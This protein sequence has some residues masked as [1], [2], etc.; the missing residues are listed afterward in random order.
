MEY[1][2]HGTPF[3]L[4]CKRG[5]VKQCFLHNPKQ[6]VNATN[7]ISLYLDHTI[8]DDDLELLKFIWKAEFSVQEQI[9]R[10][11]LAHDIQHVAERLDKMFSNFIIHKFFLYA[12]T[13]EKGPAPGDAEIIFCLGEGGKYLIEN[14][15]DE[16]IVWN[17]ENLSLSGSL[18]SKHLIDTEL[19][20]DI[21]FGA[22]N[23]EVMEYRKRPKF[24]LDKDTLILNSNY[25]FN[26]EG[27]NY[28][29]VTD[30]I[31][32]TQDVLK[33]RP[34][35]RL[36]GMLFES[37]IWRKYYPDT[38]KA[39]M[40]LFIVDTDEDAGRLAKEIASTTRLQ[41]ENYRFT[42]SERMK[43]GIGTDK[44]FILYDKD[45]DELY[46]TGINIFK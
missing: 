22:S 12:A 14:Y 8:D 3:S 10:Y 1:I 4:Y 44:S 19:W 38:A 35:I 13:S 7:I 42:T 37:N 36:I 16:Y 2:K 46:E 33:L 27:R 23:L 17:L 20:L 32:S 39:P 45:N 21:M 41:A 15:I 28:Y 18:I 25:L 31:G 24:Y 11:A 43:E 6:V 30:V 9:N 5:R 29:M 26:I 40:I 34:R